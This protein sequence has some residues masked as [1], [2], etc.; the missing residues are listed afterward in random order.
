[1]DIRPAHFWLTGTES[2]G[3]VRT[4]KAAKSRIPITRFSESL[5]AP[6]P[7]PTLTSALAMISAPAPA[8]PTQQAEP[9]ASVPAPA[10]SWAEIEMIVKNYLQQREAAAETPAAVRPIEMEPV[11]KREIPGSGKPVF[12]EPDTITVDPAAGLETETPE[13]T[14]ARRNAGLARVI[15]DSLRRRH[16]NPPVAISQSPITSGKHEYRSR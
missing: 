9:P 16:V 14:A 5:I 6:A 7:A 10:L 13:Q 15:E 2:S 3:L 8:V 1:M 4:E 12:M 11:R